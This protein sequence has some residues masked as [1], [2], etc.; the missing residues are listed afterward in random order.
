MKAHHVRNRTSAF[1]AIQKLQTE[2][3]WCLSGTPVQNSLDDLFTL[4]E[5]LQ[6]YPVDNRQNARRWVLEPL[7]TKEDYAIENFRRL[8]MTVA[9][10]RSR[11]SEMKQTRSDSEIVVTLSHP[12]RQQYDS[13][14]TK[15][16]DWIASTNKITP[17]HTLLSCIHQLRQICS[18]GLY[19]GAST[20]EPAAAGGPLPSNTVCNKCLEAIPDDLILV[21]S[22]AESG[23]PTY[24]QE[25]A[26][27]DRSNPSSITDFSSPQSR[28]CRDTSSPKTWTAV[29]ATDISGG[30]DNGSIDLSA[31]TVSRPK[32]SSKIESV[33]HNLVLLEQR[34]HPGLTPIKR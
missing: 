15:A 12:E 3:R 32:R 1:H 6:F 21:S 7:G 27:E 22:L 29:G 20:S 18:H 5:F 34:R 19:G 14:L 11:N 30:D 13:I 28:I 26:A 17:T 2:R 24:C 23:E 16:R 10:R 4:T 25:C 31:T 9:L 8:I 33:V